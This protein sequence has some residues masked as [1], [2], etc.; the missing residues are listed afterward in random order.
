MSISGGQEL[1]NS[2]PLDEYS[3]FKKSALSHPSA[4]NIL[5]DCRQDSGTADLQVVDSICRVLMALSAFTRRRYRRGLAPLCAYLVRHTTEEDSFWILCGLATTRFRRAY[6]DMLDYNGRLRSLF[7]TKSFDILEGFETPEQWMNVS[8]ARD[9][10]NNQLVSE[11]YARINKGERPFSEFSLIFEHCR[12]DAGIMN[13]LSILAPMCRVLIALS[14][15]TD[16]SYRRGLA[17]LCAFLLRH[18]TE[19][20]TFWIMVGLANTRF[21]CA[22][23]DF[24]TDGTSG[25]SLLSFGLFDSI[26]VGPSCPN[27]LAGYC[28]PSA[29]RHWMRVSGGHRLQVKISREQRLYWDDDAYRKLTVTLD[30][31]FLFKVITDIYDYMGIIN[32]PKDTFRIRQMIRIQVALRAVTEQYIC[33]L[34][35]LCD[36]LLRRGVSEQNVFW[37]LTSLLLALQPEGPDDVLTLLSQRMSEILETSVAGV[38]FASGPQVVEIPSY[39]GASRQEKELLWYS[40]EEEENMRADGREM[41]YVA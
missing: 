36:V 30:L 22:Y 28:S 4:A 12:E 18:A 26:D 27:R 10:K 32:T 14:D 16:E 35:A 3:Q 21:P 1:K 31:K 34:Q 29:E 39:T 23:K 37:M 40:A 24:V 17:P 13:D 2:H 25:F 19:E 5:K 15:F 38:C 9:W 7:I 20:D 11:S 8:G 6:R 41:G 33:G